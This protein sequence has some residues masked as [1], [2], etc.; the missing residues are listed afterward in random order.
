[1]LSFK[2]RTGSSRDFS[3]SPSSKW[4][5]TLVIVGEDE[6]GNEEEWHLTSVT[7]LSVEVGFLTATS[8]TQSTFTFLRHWME[9]VLTRYYLLFLPENGVLVDDTLMMT[10]RS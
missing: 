1:M 6:S 5:P 8:S 9:F 4:D 7:P 2:V 10:K 3:Y